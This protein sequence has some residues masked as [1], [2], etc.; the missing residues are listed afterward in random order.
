MAAPAR[1]RTV[2]LSALADVVLVVAFA[3]L[4]LASH[5]GGVGAAGLGRVAWPFLVAL[6]AAWAIARAW[7]RPLAPLRTGVVVWVVTAAGGLLLRVASGEGAA[8]PFVIVTAVVLAA[9]LIGWRAVSHVS[10][11]AGSRR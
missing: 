3:A 5:E 4:G 6:A 1:S 8:I 7:R 11:R 9:F 2:A 10:L